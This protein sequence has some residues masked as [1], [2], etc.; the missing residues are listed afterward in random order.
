MKNLNFLPLACT[1]LI[2]CSFYS[3]S[4]DE[5]VTDQPLV[6]I[7]L[8]RSQQEII[9]SEG[10]FAFELMNQLNSG[11]ED[12]NSNVSFSPLGLFVNLSMLANGMDDEAYKETQDALKLGEDVDRKALNELTETLLV[13]LLN[14]D[15]RTDVK[16]ASSLWMNN[17]GVKVYPETEKNLRQ[18]YSATI[19]TTDMGSDKAKDEIN[20]WCSQNTS[21]LIKN[22]YEKA[23]ACDMALLNTVYFNGKWTN[24][25]YVENT[26][27]ETFYNLDGS[28]STVEMM[29]Q[30]TGMLTVKTDDLAVAR[31]G[32][33]NGAY[34]LYII[35]P[36]EN[37]D[38]DA[39]LKSVN[40]EKWREL[41][42]ELSDGMV[43]VKLPK[44]GLDYRLDAVGALSGMGIKKLF[45]D[46][47]SALIDFASF[48]SPELDLNIYQ[49]SQFNVDENGTKYA[50]VTSSELIATSPGYRPATEFVVNRPFMYLITEWS[51]GTVLAMGRVNKL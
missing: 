29:S 7:E 21:G 46:P 10:S 36:D 28:E 24:P 5:T 42:G 47:C 32:Y 11:E 33:G 45:R 34:S 39:V 3:C 30:K 6:R 40:G 19:R 51:T 20:S 41:Q 31:I 27:E 8:S 4:S 26:Q 9:D 23:P 12:K 44:F 50:A 15:N 1:A 14:A 25:F 37:S 49:K 13:R 38:Y 43:T 48:D 2:S 17:K 35:L 18:Y 22:F 16:F